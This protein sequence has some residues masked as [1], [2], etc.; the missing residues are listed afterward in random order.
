[1]EK[2]LSTLPVSLGPAHL[3]ESLK[4]VIQLLIDLCTNPEEALN[5]LPTAAG[6]CVCVRACVC[7]CVR[8]C[9]HVC[10]CTSLLFPPQVLWW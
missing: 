1:M 10:V 7:T 4:N 6:V 8:A 9:V 5:R 3:A 2:L